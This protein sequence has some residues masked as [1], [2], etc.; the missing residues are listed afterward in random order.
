MMSELRRAATTGAQCAAR[1]FSTMY[2]NSMDLLA[3]R[4]DGPHFQ[5]TLADLR[6]GPVGVGGYIFQVNEP[7]QRRPRRQ[8]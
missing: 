8:M 5:N 6:E 3:G 2:H 7:A 1:S 4:D